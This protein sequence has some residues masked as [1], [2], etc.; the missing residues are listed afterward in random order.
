MLVVFTL[1]NYFVHIDFS[2]VQHVF[3]VCAWL[4]SLVFIDSCLSFKALLSHLIGFT[5]IA[6]LHVGNSLCP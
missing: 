6:Q 1:I 3:K 2:K 4:S 5:R